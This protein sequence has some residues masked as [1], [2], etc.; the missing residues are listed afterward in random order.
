M[1][2]Y[3]SSICKNKNR[4][5]HSF[6]YSS[7]TLTHIKLSD[8]ISMYTKQYHMNPCIYYKSV[9]KVCVDR[10]KPS[11]PDTVFCINH[12]IIASTYWQHVLGAPFPVH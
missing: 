2:P 8:I 5:K 1:R 10:S 7:L 11:M 9:I 12:V 6:G 3:K 4:Y